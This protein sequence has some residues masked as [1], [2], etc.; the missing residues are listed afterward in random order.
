MPLSEFG[1]RLRAS[2]YMELWDRATDDLEENETFVL[3]ERG[4]EDFLM[5]FLQKAKFVVFGPEPVFSYALAKKRELDLVRLVGLGKICMMPIPFIK[6]R[7]SES[8]V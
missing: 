7:I 4:I 2:D 1:Q 6:N 5:N 3:L 8:Y